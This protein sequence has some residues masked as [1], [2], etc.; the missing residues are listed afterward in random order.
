MLT[1]ATVR[2]RSDILI[3]FCLRLF[4]IYKRLFYGTTLRLD[5]SLLHKGSAFLGYF[6]IGRPSR[7]VILKQWLFHVSLRKERVKSRFFQRIE[8][9]F[10]QKRPHAGEYSVGQG[11][12]ASP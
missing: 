12:K 1:T 7:L 3:R 10:S 11:D 5:D 8:H 4:A 6:G 9:H 2:V